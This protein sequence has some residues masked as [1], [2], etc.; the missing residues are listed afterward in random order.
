MGYYFGESL[1]QSPL[2]GA[3]TEHDLFQENW[4]QM[5]DEGPWTDD[6][7][8]YERIQEAELVDWGT[9]TD[10]VNPHAFEVNTHWPMGRLVFDVLI[11]GM[12]HEDALTQEADEL[13]DLTS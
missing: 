5:K 4:Q 6:D 11:D 3:I 12:S 8:Q 13:R 2:L 9:E 1:Q 10:T 7:L